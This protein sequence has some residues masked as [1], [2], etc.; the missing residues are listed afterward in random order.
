MNKFIPEPLRGVLWLYRFYIYIYIYIYIYKYTRALMWA[1]YVLL[2]RA[3]RTLA[4]SIS[5]CVA[6]NAV[7]VE[8]WK[9]KWCNR[10]WRKDWGGSVRRGTMR[11]APSRN[12]ALILKT[13][14]CHFAFKTPASAQVGS[15]SRYPSIQTFASIEICLR[16]NMVYKDWL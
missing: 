6:L 13:L 2:L 11:R 5:S 12:A 3:S 9:L 1:S 7:R 4:N 14:R 15:I 16:N 8:R 10:N